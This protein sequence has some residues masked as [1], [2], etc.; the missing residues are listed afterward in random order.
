MTVPTSL[1]A[2]RRQ[3]KGG[4]VRCLAALETDPLAD[5]VLDLLD[6]A[7]RVGEGVVIGLTGPPGVGKSSLLSVLARAWRDRGSTLAVLAVDPSSRRTGGALL[8]DR[9]RLA[10]DPGDPGLFVRS[11]AAR[12]RLGGLADLCAPATVLLAALFDRVI[13]ETVGVG[14][15]ESEIRDLADLVLLA[16]QPAAGDGLQFMK[17]GILEVPDLLLVTKADLGEPAERT[18]RELEAACLLRGE[19]VPVHAIST[20][21]REGVEGL[22]RALEERIASH[23]SRPRDTRRAE[24][25]DALLRAAVAGEFGRWG[26]RA[27]ARWREEVGLD[28]ALSPFRHL[29]AFT[30]CL[31]GERP[32]P[33]VAS[34]GGPRP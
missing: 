14:Q 8:G 25:S 22:L 7:W 24:R 2:L 1:A 33:P 9:T 17:A 3:G 20:V 12:D 32:R 6:E 10:L 4:L 27:L 5:T 30:E 29:R 15:S 19:K 26:L 13:V 21:T 23:R 18:R 31:A 34:T 11:L 28:P 16:V